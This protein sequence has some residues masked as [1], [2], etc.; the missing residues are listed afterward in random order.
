MLERSDQLANPEESD[1]VPDEIADDL[2]KENAEVTGPDEEHIQM[3]AECGTS[4]VGP[5]DEDPPGG[6]GIRLWPSIILDPMQGY[7]L[8]IGVSTLKHCNERSFSAHTLQQP[9]KDS[10]ILKMCT[11]RVFRRKNCD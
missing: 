11:I 10:N 9:R 6:N 4:T 1:N 5:K 7:W 2:R 3:E 8:K